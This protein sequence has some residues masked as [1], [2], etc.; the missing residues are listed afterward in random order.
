MSNEGAKGDSIIAESILDTC[1]ELDYGTGIFEL[2]D[3]TCSTDTELVCSLEV[4]TWL[5]LRCALLS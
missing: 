3:R 1:T 4:A 2:C 5:Q